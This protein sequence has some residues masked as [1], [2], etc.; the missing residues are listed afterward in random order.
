M[1]GKINFI[2]SFRLA[3]ERTYYQRAKTAKI[4]SSGENYIDQIIEWERQ[5]A[6]QFAYLRN[7]L[8][9]LRLLV[10]LHSRRIRGGRYEVSIK[11]GRGGIWSAVTDVGFGISQFLPIAVA[12]IQLG[13]GSTLIV[14][15]PEIHLHPSIQAA[16]GGYFVQRIK[17][18]R[19]RYIIETHS[20]Y[21]IN[22]I[23][24]LIAKGEIETS[25]IA[26]YHFQRKG[27]DTA[28]YP[29]QFTKEGKIEGAPKDFF[30][31]YMMEVMDIAMSTE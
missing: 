1:G 23:T 5:R 3:P 2:S 31:T 19:K 15:Q 7:A 21:L 26:V 10:A 11:P 30:N 6:K 8:Q 20:E 29:V 27:C 22:R 13:R 14:A 24:L 16:L 17:S 4:G 9:E 12:D 28:V 18:E 25:R